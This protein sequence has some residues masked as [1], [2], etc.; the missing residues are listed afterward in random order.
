MATELTKDMKL[1]TLSD[2]GMGMH[3]LQGVEG[4]FKVRDIPAVVAA[5]YYEWH[6]LPQKG[7]EWQEAP[8]LDKVLYTWSDSLNDEYMNETLEHNPDIT[9]GEFCNAIN[10]DIEETLKLH[11]SEVDEESRDFASHERELK[12]IAAY[13]AE[14]A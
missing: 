6:F 4:F 1:Q 9:V 3:S 10:E 11:E 5:G 14:V 8:D 12:N 7:Y 2:E 13:K